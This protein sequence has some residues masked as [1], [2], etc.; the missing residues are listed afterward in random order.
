MLYS[1]FVTGHEFNYYCT[2][3][4]ALIDRSLRVY[5]ELAEGLLSGSCNLLNK[6]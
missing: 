5:P 3:D 6:L 2:S 1:L 4:I